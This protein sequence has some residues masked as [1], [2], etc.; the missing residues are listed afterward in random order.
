MTAPPALH[1]FVKV[2]VGLEGVSL[3]TIG[4][5]GV[6]W[7]TVNDPQWVSETNILTSCISAKQ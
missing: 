4:T 1:I 5:T 7:S 2:H 6:K 3:E